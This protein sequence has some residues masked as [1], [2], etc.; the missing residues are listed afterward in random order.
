MSSRRNRG[1]GGGHGGGGGE[2]R[3][4]LP[5]ADMI[6]LLLGL[7]IVLFA[8]SSINAQQ[9]DQV[10]K[11]LAQTFNGG[12]AL[13]GSG[14]VLP[15]ADGVL[16]PTAPSSGKVDSPVTTDVAAR[17]TAQQESQRQF[18]AEA[19]KLQQQA[20]QLGLGK[21]VSVTR[22][23]IGIQI[24]IAGDALF[25][26]GSYQLTSPGIIDELTRIEKELLR[27][28]RPI[29]IEGHTDGQPMDGEFG[30]QGLSNNR[31]AAVWK[32]FLDNGFPKPLM[33]TVGMGDVVPKVQPKYPAEP[34]AANRRI[35]IVVL[36]PG[37]EDALANAAAEERA[38]P[39]AKPASTQRRTSVSV[40]DAAHA[41][42]QDKVASEFD[43]AL[44]DQIGAT[45][46]GQ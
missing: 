33:Y 24:S 15:G 46:K 3:W 11:S 22:T 37:I 9:F 1:G 10:R 30:N 8:M 38:T 29:R 17:T 27:F 12:K 34:V 43:G 25:A 40:S 39:A 5:Y 18:D 32:F 4:L 19:Q 2:E 23:E 44:I 7:F 14:G 13:E 16:S 36:E 31:A 45:G 28:G 26:P 6:T 35:E 41:Q 21:D 42:V 20:Q